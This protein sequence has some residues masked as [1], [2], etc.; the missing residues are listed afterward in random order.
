M[1]AGARGD[2]DGHGREVGRHAPAAGAVGA[3]ADGGVGAVVGDDLRHEG[4][5]VIR[6]GAGG[7]SQADGCPRTL[8]VK[9]AGAC[10]VAYLEGPVGGDFY[11]FCVI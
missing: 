6:R 3:G 9:R 4:G 1:S 8:D 11:Y 2:G 10:I 7:V 5:V